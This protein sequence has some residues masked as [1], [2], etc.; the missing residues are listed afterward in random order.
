MDT[1]RVLALLLC[2]LESRFWV[3]LLGGTAGKLLINTP[4]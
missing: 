2:F 4:G 3:W 1:E